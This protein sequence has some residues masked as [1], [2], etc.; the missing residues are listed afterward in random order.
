MGDD[1]LAGNEDLTVEEFNK[2]YMRKEVAHSLIG[3]GVRAVSPDAKVI[4]WNW[5]WNIYGPAHMKKSFL[6]FQMT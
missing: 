5:S 4:V 6:C 1:D 3:D 2:R